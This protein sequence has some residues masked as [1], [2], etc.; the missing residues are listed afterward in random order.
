MSSI[1]IKHV[2]KHLS[3]IIC[4][5]L[6]NDLL[7]TA[8]F[9]SERLVALDGSD[10]ESRHLL[11]KTLLKL[12]QPHSALHLV[13]RAGDERC[14]ECLVIAAGCNEQ[15][16]RFGKAR[17]IM[18]EALRVPGTSTIPEDAK[19]ECSSVQEVV[20][21]ICIALKIDGAREASLNTA[22]LHCKAGRLAAKASQ[23]QEAID[24]FYAALS[25]D[26]L[27]WEAWV[28]ITSLGLSSYRVRYLTS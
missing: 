19:R 12:D 13:S 5:Y 20:V 15:L 8:L 27:L 3:S 18:A 22:A 21:L 10:H 16:L 25:L 11:A 1:D 4:R 2:H 6:S 24:S 9:Y 7:K 28:G 17:E 14:K 23:K 26:P